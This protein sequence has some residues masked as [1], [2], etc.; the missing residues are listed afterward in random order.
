MSPNVLRG[1]NLAGKFTARDI[2]V[3]WRYRGMKTDKFERSG[4]L[5]GIAIDP[6]T[7]FS[8]VRTAPNDNGAGT[9]IRT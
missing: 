2:A 1:A 5:G 4:Q 7:L 3:C 9:R 8:L 6:R